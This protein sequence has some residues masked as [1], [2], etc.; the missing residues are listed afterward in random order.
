VL[1]ACLYRTQSVEISCVV[2][3]RSTSLPTRHQAAS[4][5]IAHPGTRQRTTSLSNVKP[6][7]FR[8]PTKWHHQ[9]RSFRPVLTG[10]ADSMDVG[11]H[12]RGVRTSSRNCGSRIQHQ[13]PRLPVKLEL[14]SID[15][16]EDEEDDGDGDG[17]D[18]VI[19]SDEQDHHVLRSLHYN[20]DK[21]RAADQVKGYL[22]GDAQDDKIIPIVRPV[23]TASK[24][25]RVS[26]VRITFVQM[27]LWTLSLLSFSCFDT[28]CC[29]GREETRPSSARNRVSR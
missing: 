5:I 4:R 17:D 23:G 20:D 12:T 28:T 25:A 16:H 18:D 2:S 6:D 15:S 9:T 13:Q 24:P 22:T 11:S 27:R 29:V 21:A 1:P 3:L 8:H 19:M 7:P 10:M 26:K 14:S